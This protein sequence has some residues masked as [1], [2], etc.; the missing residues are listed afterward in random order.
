M[1]YSL[2]SLPANGCED[3][4]RKNNVRIESISERSDMNARK[5][6]NLHARQESVHGTFSHSDLM[7]NDQNWEWCRLW[8]EMH[9]SNA[10]LMEPSSFGAP[11]YQ[12]S[13]NKR[14]PTSLVFLAAVSQLPVMRPPCCDLGAMQRPLSRTFKI[15][16]LHTASSQ[17]SLHTTP[18]RC[19]MRS[20]RQ[21][22][23]AA[24]CAV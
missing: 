20:G 22:S 11:L 1:C 16:L 2:E 14:L 7:V 13:T 12:K 17:S 18:V 10:G 24:M 3:R 15:G 19:F 9:F 4:L 21:F 8:P 23:H 5:C 6:E